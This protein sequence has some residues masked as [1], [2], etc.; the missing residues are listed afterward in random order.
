M[1]QQGTAL[2]GFSNP[3]KSAAVRPA[4]PAWPT[5]SIASINASWDPAALR[6]S[7]AWRVDDKKLPQFSYKLIATNLADGST[8]A[9]QSANEPHVRNFSVTLPAG[10]KNTQGF[11]V[12]LELVDPFDGVSAAQTITIPPETDPT[13][14]P[15][16]PGAPYRLQNV[17]TG[18]YMQVQASSAAAAALVVQSD[19]QNQLSQ[20]WQFESTGTAGNYAMK[21]AHTLQCLD[22]PKSSTDNG[23][24]LI[25]YPCHGTKNQQV[26]LGAPDAFGARVLTFAHSSKCVDAVQ[27]STTNPS[28]AVLQ[29]ACHGG[30]NQRWRLV[31]VK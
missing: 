2:S 12:Q 20:Q 6:L 10:T 29:Y 22:I 15:P 25:Q 4:A 16:P 5:V 17:A 18:K 9:G 23:V 30:N 31:P 8:L 26:R 24:Q 19:L 11:V 7:A 13:Q 27:T 1:L 14:A 21:A 28:L 3:L